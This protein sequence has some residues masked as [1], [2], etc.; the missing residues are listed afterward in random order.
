MIRPGDGCPRTVTQAPTARPSVARAG[1]N[2]NAPARA[3]AIPNRTAETVFTDLQF[4]AGVPRRLERRDAGLSAAEDE[5]VDVVR[6]LVGVH[7]FQVHQVADD[8][9][10]VDDA[11]AAVHVARGARDVERLAAGIALEHGHHLGR[12]FAF[13]LE[14]PEAQAGRERERDLGLHVGELFLDELVGGQGLAEGGARQG[15]VARR[16]PAELG[17]A[18]RAPGYPVARIVEAGERSL[19]AGYARQ[20]VFLRHEHVVHRDLAGDRGAQTEL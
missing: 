7:G 6:A 13:V 9:I 4:I 11:V 2:K 8:V 15:V 14:P 5:G 10:F 16:K 20:V 1:E 3:A 17:G 12:R 19:E 18:H